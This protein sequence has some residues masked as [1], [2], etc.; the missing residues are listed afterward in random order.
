VVVSST[1]SLSSASSRESNMYTSGPTSLASTHPAICIS[2]DASYMV[3]E[4]DDVVVRLRLV[5]LRLVRLR[6]VRLRLVRRTVASLSSSLDS[7]V[8]R[9]RAF[10]PVRWVTRYSHFVPRLAQRAH[11]G[12]SF[13]HLV[14]D[15]AH[16]WQLSRRRMPV[17]SGMGG[18][19]VWCDGNGELPT[20]RITEALCN[21]GM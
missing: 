5:R 7:L 20:R 10:L 21:L 14:L 12:F 19:M 2:G 9:D 6:L 13:E 15:A 16:D 8:R 1:M 3:A 18:S 11:R 4:E 17:G